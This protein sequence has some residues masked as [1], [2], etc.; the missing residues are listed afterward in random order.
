MWGK[1]Q[2]YRIM[3]ASFSWGIPRRY[4]SLSCTFWVN[5]AASYL[6]GNPPKSGVYSR[7][8]L[9]RRLNHLYCFLSKQRRSLSMPECLLT[10]LIPLFHCVSF[11]KLLPSQLQ[12]NCLGVTSSWVDRARQQ[13]RQH[14]EIWQKS[15]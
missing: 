10:A 6:L 13:V 3:N 14:G 1:L 11:W 2:Q 8:F 4:Q 9:I 12:E 7:K 15:K 5:P